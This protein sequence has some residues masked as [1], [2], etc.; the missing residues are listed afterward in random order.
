MA[1]SGEKGK[2]PLREQRA[3]TAADG[4]PSRPERNADQG[5]HAPP[6]NETL[7]E[8][9]AAAPP[10]PAEEAQK[11]EPK[12]LPWNPAGD[13][14][15]L[16]PQEQR[17]GQRRLEEKDALPPASDSPVPERGAAGKTPH[18][19]QARAASAYLEKAA[20]LAPG[21]DEREKRGASSASPI[22]LDYRGRDPDA[23]RL[24]SSR[25]NSM[26]EEYRRDGGRSRTLRNEIVLACGGLV[27]YAVLSTR[28]MYQKYC[29]DSDVANEAVLALMKALDTFQ[30]DK[31]AKF[32]TYVSMK[33]RGA[34]IDYIRRQDVIPR[35]VRKFSREM[36]AAYSEMYTRLGREPSTK[37][38]AEELGLSEERLSKQMADAASAATLS[39]EELL[40]DDNFDISAKMADRDDSLEDA[41]T[42]KELSSKLAEAIDGLKERQRLVVTLYY[43]ERLKFSDIAKIL[44]VTESRICQIHSKAM[45][46]LRYALEEY[47]GSPRE[48]AS[49]AKTSKRGKKKLPGL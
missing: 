15:A 44:E 14:P 49:P 22:P 5:G 4:L 27:Q 40:Y 31:G 13:T 28:N 43:Y 17:D 42:G 39:F 3:E 20:V 30:P 33:M 19:S 41:V 48:S 36:Q 29:E 8:K 37:E 1:S 7:L 38:L 16:P 10:M 45:L 2:D 11:A 46:N 35:S 6:L 12:E 32:E 24:A 34:I 23:R 18:L 26:A 25:L 47:L 9:K 21:K